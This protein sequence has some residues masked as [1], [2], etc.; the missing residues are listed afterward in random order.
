MILYLE[1]ERG[2]QILT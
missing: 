1:T 2:D